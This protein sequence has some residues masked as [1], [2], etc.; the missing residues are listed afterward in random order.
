M[1]KYPWLAERFRRALCRISPMLNTKVTYKMKFHRKLDLND[2]KTLNEKIQ[3]L[4]FNTY[5]DDPLVKQCA[6]KYAVRKYVEDCGLKQ[7]LNEL[8]AAY[9]SPE[10]IEWDRLPDRFALKMNVGCGMNHIVSDYSAEDPE[11]LRKEVRKWFRASRTQWLGY[12]ELQYRDVKPYALVEKYLGNAEKKTFPEDYKVYCFNGRAEFVLVCVG[13]ESGDIPKYYF[14]DRDWNLARINRD[15][16]N[17]P[18]GFTIP[19]PACMDEL[20]GAA[21]TL[22]KPFP[23]VRADFYIHEDRVIFGELTFTPAGGMDT[24][25]LPET[26]KFMGEMLKLPDAE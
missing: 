1:Q 8:I 4:K 18:E 25:R 15:S 13:R 19:K 14:L 7:I 11:A 10:K 20:F 24:A 22:S 12:S 9:D 17:A 6:D 26:D 3:W 2:P 21:E 16:K 5:R 23:F